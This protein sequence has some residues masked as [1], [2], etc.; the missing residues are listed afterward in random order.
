MLAL[1][2]SLVASSSQ[3]VVVLPF[4]ADGSV[5]VKQAHGVTALVR[6]ALVDGK[7]AKVLDESGDDDK[8]AQKC[9]KNIACY[10]A[11]ADVR[12]ADL[13]VAGTVTPAADG[14]KVALFAVQPK[15]KTA[16]RNA[17]VVLKGDDGDALRIE[18]LAR[19]VVDP[20]SLTGAIEITGDDGAEVLVDGRSLGAIPIENP[21]ENL[22]EGDHVVVVKKPGYEEFNQSVRVTFKETA[23][24]HAVLL[25]AKATSP[26]AALSRINGAP[27]SHVDAYVVGGVGVGL[28]VI[29]VVTGALSLKDSLDVEARAKAQQ[30]AFPTDTGLVQR[31]AIEAYAADGLYAGALVAGGAAVALY[32]LDGGDAKSGAE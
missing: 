8:Q 27:P 25:G 28:A 24:V 10:G 32:V 2:L 26:T 13:V 20:A 17:E 6:N 30:L 11:L 19:Q 4:L 18:R 21:V 15:M 5:S 9:Q 1:A 31:G 16:L 23:K 22:S 14:L 29:G 3:A 12:G 7:V